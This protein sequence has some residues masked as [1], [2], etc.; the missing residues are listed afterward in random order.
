MANICEFEM[1]VSGPNKSAALCFADEIK[2]M[3]RV[4]NADVYDYYDEA[5]YVRVVGSCA[6]SLY[7]ALSIGVY[8]DGCDNTFEAEAIRLGITLEAY[9]EEGECGFGEHYVF[10]DGRLVVNESAK[11]KRVFIDELD[12]E[13]LE[14]LRVFGFS[15]E[16][17]KQECIALGGYGWTYPGTKQEPRH[18]ASSSSYD[19][20]PLMPMPPRNKDLYIRPKTVDVKGI[21]SGSK[22]IF[23][24]DEL[25]DAIWSWREKEELAR[26]LAYQLSPDGNAPIR[27]KKSCASNRM[28]CKRLHAHVWPLYCDEG[29]ARSISELALEG[30]ESWLASGGLTYGM[31]GYPYEAEEASTA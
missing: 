19:I 3:G 26:E 8:G 18:G 16:E 6:W 31:E 22:G 4:Y 15:D 11:F 5:S 29:L 12:A 7:T 30:I 27:A 9:S 10:K 21:H 14:E 23:V 28:Q 20:V 17:L 13:G 25:V 24:S 1:V 2:E